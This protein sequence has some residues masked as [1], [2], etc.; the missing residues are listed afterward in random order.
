[1]NKE[2]TYNEPIIDLV[3]ERSFLFITLIETSV[4]EN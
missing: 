1:M 3:I 4:C 2:I